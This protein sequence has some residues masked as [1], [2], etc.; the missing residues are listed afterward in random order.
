MYV[1]QNSSF[2][3]NIKAFRL[4]AFKCSNQSKSAQ[5]T[6]NT[7]QTAN[8]VCLQSCGCLSVFNFHQ[9]QQKPKALKSWRHWNWAVWSYSTVTKSVWYRNTTN[10]LQNEASQSTEA[11]GGWYKVSHEKQVKSRVDHQGLLHGGSYWRQQEVTYDMYE[12]EE[13]SYK[14]L[15][16]AKKYSLSLSGFQWE[17]P[18]FNNY[19]HIQNKPY[20]CFCQTV[21]TQ[22]IGMT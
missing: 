3:L 12:A 13:N 9:G 22:S 11:G 2:T 1:L 19:T 16:E 6:D 7:V 4:L 18:H 20:N 10:S 15:K 21:C 17:H 5:I 14:T 8:S